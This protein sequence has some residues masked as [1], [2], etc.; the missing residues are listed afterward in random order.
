MNQMGSDWHMSG[1]FGR[2]VLCFARQ[3]LLPLLQI[4]VGD[5]S[6]AWAFAEAERFRSHSWWAGP[7]HR[8]RKLLQWVISKCQLQQIFAWNCW[9]FWILCFS[10]Y[11]KLFLT[12]AVW[13]SLIRCEF[14][15][16]KKRVPL[17]G[18]LL[19]SC[20]HRPRALWIVRCSSILLKKHNLFSQSL[21]APLMLAR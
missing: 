10:W 17:D 14:S 11:C 8:F 1:A 6:N 15:L 4:C 20:R 5:G 3:H 13:H 12:P 7:A 19:T 2:V 21:V 9:R 18:L 16:V